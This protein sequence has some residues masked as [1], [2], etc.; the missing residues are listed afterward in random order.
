MGGAVTVTAGFD[1]STTRTCE[2][3]ENVIQSPSIVT[4]SISL[5]NSITFIKVYT[6]T[7]E[8]NHTSNWWFLG[9]FLDHQELAAPMTHSVAEIEQNSWCLQLHLRA[10]VFCVN[11][12]HEPKCHK[13][14]QGHSSKLVHSC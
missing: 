8:L 11:G 14:R 6:V 13:E 1:G 2:M 9:H 5:P 10:L 12:L 3:S 4:A 7:T